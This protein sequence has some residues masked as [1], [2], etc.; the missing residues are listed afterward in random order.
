MDFFTR[1]FFKLISELTAKGTKDNLNA[2]IRTIK[3]L[4][5][6]KIEDFLRLLWF[7]FSYGHQL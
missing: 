3:V 6:V 2:M 1:N 5:R 7:F 4:K